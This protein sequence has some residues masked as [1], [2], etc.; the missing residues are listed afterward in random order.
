MAY[1]RTHKHFYFSLGNSLLVCPQREIT[2]SARDRRGA[3]SV[4]AFIAYSDLRQF[5]HGTS[6]FQYIERFNWISESH[7][8]LHG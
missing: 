6:D 3:S 7:Q 4:A 8:L 2:A 1:L 5:Q